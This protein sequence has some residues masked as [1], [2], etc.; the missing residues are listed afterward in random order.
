MS[1]L[2]PP[3]STIRSIIE[4]S[5]F[6]AR[7]LLM[8]IPSFLNDIINN[9]IPSFIKS[10]ITFLVNRIHFLLFVLITVIS[11]IPITF[12][13]GIQ[14]FIKM[15]I[16]NPNPRLI[17][18]T[19]EKIQFMMCDTMVGLSVWY[20]DV[21]NKNSR[22]INNYTNDG[23]IEKLPQHDNILLRRKEIINKRKEYRLVGDTPIP[24]TS[25][26]L[27][28]YQPLLSRDVFPVLITAYFSL[29]VFINVIAKKF[30]NKSKNW[31]PLP[32]AH[33]PIN[34]MPS[35][36]IDNDDWFCENNVNGMNP[37][38]IERIDLA[39]LPSDDVWQNLKMTLDSTNKIFF[40]M[41]LYEYSNLPTKTNNNQYLAKPRAL[42]GYDTIRSKFEP[43]AIQLDPNHDY[44]VTPNDS[45]HV[46]RYAKHCFYVTNMWCAQLFY[47]ISMHG[48]WEYLSVLLERT[49]STKHPVY[50]LIYPFRRMIFA[51]NTLGRTQALFNK[52]VSIIEKIA[53]VDNNYWNSVILAEVA[54]WSFDRVSFK[55]RNKNRKLAGLD[56]F[57]YGKVGGMYWNVM[58]KY[59][60]NV[61][62]TYYKTNNDFINDVEIQN[63]IREVDIS[64]TGFAVD[65]LNDF[66]DNIT[67][68][69]FIASI[70]HHVGHNLE[71]SAKGNPKVCSYSLYAPVATKKSDITLDLIEKTMQ[72]CEMAYAEQIWDIS[73][74]VNFSTMNNAD[75]ISNVYV[76]SLLKQH[77]INFINEYNKLVIPD[78]PYIFNY[79]IKNDITSH[80]TY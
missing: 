32:F 1:T 11:A 42:F 35:N 73:V 56:M 20:A 10:P 39:D 58:R 30:K 46:W 61:I 53:A 66:I 12:I 79:L 51:I 22:F 49:L 18:S 25:Y 34:F 59:V 7:G 75:D 24:G 55:K 41:D 80:M 26:F 36:I 37:I 2:T 54:K 65:N 4:I 68:L 3:I 74:S 67:D 40:W 17:L 62:T 60:H 64:T 38:A 63:F 13:Y 43:I 27:A 57:Y 45:I 29:F 44:L 70:D 19:V 33:I 76:D 72:T 15:Y 77:A 48:K 50:R 69:L 21:L 31:D 16:T 5:Y 28:P 8:T 23:S 9:T 6:M 52:T 78:H 47:H 14:S 71:Y